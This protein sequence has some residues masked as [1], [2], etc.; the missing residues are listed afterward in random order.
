MKKQQTKAQKF[1][2]LLPEIE[3]LLDEYLQEAVVEILREKHDLDINLNTFKNYLH[4]Y[5]S[6][7]ENTTVTEKI[8]QPTPNQNSV[9]SQDLNNADEE[10]SPDI[11]KQLKDSL[12]N[13]KASFEKTSHQPNSIFNKG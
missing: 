8:S 5:R 3:Q 1:R 13:E 6:T 10:I 11:L 9:T 12:S 4:R 2:Q 7:K